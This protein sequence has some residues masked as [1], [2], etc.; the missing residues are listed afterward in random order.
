MSTTTQETP[1]QAQARVA[2]LIHLFGAIAP[3]TSLE[4]VLQ[5]QTTLGIV[6][7]LTQRV[8]SSAIGQIL[9]ALPPGSPEFLAAQQQLNEAVQTMATHR[10]FNPLR[11]EAVPDL[12]I[13]FGASVVQVIAEYALYGCQQYIDRTVQALSQVPAQYRMPGVQVDT[14]WFDPNTGE[15]QGSNN[16]ERGARLADVLKQK[17]AEAKA[18]AAADMAKQDESQGAIVGYPAEAAPNPAP[19]AGLQPEETAAL[20][21]PPLPPPAPVFVDAVST[22]TVPQQTPADS[23][24]MAANDNE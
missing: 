8:Y 11:P 18:R 22:T 20:T 17:H 12:E 13:A 16:S 19:I 15:P 24:I 5:Q 4:Q 1:E 10:G 9:G 14:E 23:T 3:G 7:D 21:S 2:Q 6:H